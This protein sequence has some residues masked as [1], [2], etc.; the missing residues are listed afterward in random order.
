MAIIRAFKGYR[1]GKELVKKVVSPPYDVLS[2]KEAREMAADNSYSYLHVVKPE[3]DLPEDVDPYSK[4]VYEKGAENLKK[5]VTE[6]TLI[7][8]EEASLYIYSQKMGAH[9][10]TGLVALTSAEEYIADK[11]K[12]HEHTK[13]DKVKDRTNHINKQGAHSGPVFL[14]YKNSGSI[15][16]II[17]KIQDAEPD[18]DITAPDGIGHTLWVVGSATEKKALIE[19]FEKIDVLYIADG[20]HRSASA[21][22]NY[23][24]DGTEATAYFLAVLFP[25]NQLKIMDYNRA[26][27]DLNG[28][29]EK[30][31]LK[32]V[33]DKFIIKEADIPKPDKRHFVGMYLDG[34]WYRLQMKE[35][36]IDENDPVKRL[37]VAILQDHLL[38]PVLGIKDPKTDKRIDFIGGIRGTEELEKI[39][40]KGDF[41]VAFAMFPLSLEELMSIADA[42][43][44]MPPKSTWFEP[45]LRSGMVVNIFREIS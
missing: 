11:I 20:H 15:D 37:D 21:V 12:K 25:D 9:F 7:R 39:V 29:S 31:F 40:A 16:R 35:E 14:T 2:S 23:S 42:K 10:Q 43:E 19:E 30:D 33:S 24:W 6:K 38:E 41:S 44:V 26:V 17:K 27:K 45:K 28:L 13:P 5:L 1:P 18:V 34:K 3:I 8:D 22:E 4:E 32:E 36:I